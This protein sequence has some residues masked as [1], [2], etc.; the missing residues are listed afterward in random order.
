MRQRLSYIICDTLRGSGGELN[1]LSLNPRVEGQIA[2]SI[3]R[4]DGQGVVLDPRTAEQLLRNLIPQ[5]E[6][7]LRE[8]IAPVL[9]CSGDVRRHLRAF[10][11]RSV[12]RLAVV[13]VNEIPTAIDLRS[14]SIIRS[15][16]EIRDRQPSDVMIGI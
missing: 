9:L 5:V 7:M 13:S 11:R 2:D 1:V 3:R 6:A 16:D 10:T 12:P 14:Y 15:R 4:S 8:Q